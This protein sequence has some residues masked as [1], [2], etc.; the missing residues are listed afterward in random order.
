MQVSR[1]RSA[2]PMGLAFLHLNA[3]DRTKMKQFKWTSKRSDAALALSMGKTEEETAQEVGVARSSITRWKK[4]IEFAVEVDR[5]TLMTGIASKA[6]RLRLA[7]K[8]IAKQLEKEVPTEKDLLDWVKYAQS[9]TDG[10]KLN[11]IGELAALFTD[12]ASVAGSGQ[13][14]SQADPDTEEPDA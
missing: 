7:K 13:A 9:E 10:V 4:E 2:G 12:G 8:M 11:L 5:L 14:G 3:Q 6:E 1:T